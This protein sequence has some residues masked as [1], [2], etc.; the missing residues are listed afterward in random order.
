LIHIVSAASSAQTLEWMRQLG[1]NDEEESRALAVDALGNAYIVGDTGGSLGAA[2]AGDY[3]AFVS[4]YDGTGALQ[5]SRQLGTSGRDRGFGLATD[6]LQNVFVAGYTEG[7]LGA[8]SA[9]EYD[10]FLSK[11]DTAGGLKWTRQ[12]G[13][14]AWDLPRALSVDANGN[15]YVTGSTRGSL[16]GANVGDY[17]VFVTKYDSTG[18][19]QWTRQYGSSTFDET[20]GASLDGL[21][22][23]YVSGYTDGSLGKPNAGSYDAFVSKFSVAGELLWTRQFGT[24]ADDR[25]LGI[26]TDQLG[27]VFVSGHTHGDLGAV[28]A[29]NRDIFV[30]KLDAAGN[31][32]WTR[33]LGTSLEDR[34]DAGANVDG[35]GGVYF[36]GYTL[37][38]LVGKGSGGYD[39]VFGHFD[40]AGNLHWVQQIGTSANDWSSGINSDHR[41]SLLL[42]GSTGGSL[43]GTNAGGDDVFL[44]K[45][46][47]VVP[48]PSALLLT[49]ISLL[50]CG[51]VRRKRQDQLLT[52]SHS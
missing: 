50:A 1:T 42:S 22:N 47:V 11:F 14:S 44:A 4:K 51:L 38:D 16:A 6:S 49:S 7:V 45:Y 19:V 36:S 41:G 2:I 34:T 32:E 30:S 10:G 5:W 39:V 3:D 17:D 24:E 29:G 20:H 8:T 48:E 25:A 33:Q 18:S 40:S 43:A 31:L 12:F 23:L 37:G 28:N 21:G 46:R 9:G 27:N 13:T 26:S 52:W 15:A 35:L